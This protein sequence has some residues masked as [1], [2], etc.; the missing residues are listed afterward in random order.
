MKGA[1]IF[2]SSSAITKKFA[3]ND[4]D[5]NLSKLLISSENKI[6][7]IFKKYSINCQIIRPTIV[8]GTYKE[9]DDRNFIK[10]IKV[11][12]FALP[13]SKQTIIKLTKFST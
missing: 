11:L 2:S 3:A 10:I 4:F 13:L 7:S 6:L 9:L 12:F 8:Y 5:K 1:I